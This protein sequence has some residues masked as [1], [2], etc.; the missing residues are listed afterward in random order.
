MEARDD[1]LLSTRAVCKDIYIQP[2]FNEGQISPSPY[3]NDHLQQ[4]TTPFN[5]YNSSNRIPLAEL[6]SGVSRSANFCPDGFDDET[7]DDFLDFL[8]FRSLSFFLSFSEED[9][10][11]SVLTFSVS[12]VEVSFFVVLL[13][14]VVAG[15]LSVLLLGFC[16]EVEVLRAFSPEL[17]DLRSAFPSE[18]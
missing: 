18:D 4:R 3:N 12:V 5:R 2:R 8:S 11:G 10:V 13:L 14:V 15:A 6:G 17:L 1:I 16:L 9:M 7:L